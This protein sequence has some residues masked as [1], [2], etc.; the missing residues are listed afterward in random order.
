M[1][2]VLAI[3]ARAAPLL[4]LV[5]VGIVGLSGLWLVVSNAARRGTLVERGGIDIGPPQ[6]AVARLDARLM[7][8]RRGTDMAARLQSA[9]VERSVGHFY[10]MRVVIVVVAFF[11]AKLLFPLILALL[12]AVAAWWAGHFWLQRKL[13]R[14][15]EEFVVQLPELARLLSNG[16]S[17]GL[18]VPAALELAVREIDNPAKAELQT[19][20]DEMSLGRSLDESLEALA[21]RLPSREVAVLMSCIVIQ[22]RAGGD[23]VHALRGLSETLENRRE[24]GREVR[25]IMAG[26]VYTAYVVPFLGLGSLLMLNAI[27]SDT[28]SRMTST[29][30]GIV[31]LIVAFVLYFI[32]FVAIRRATRV[33]L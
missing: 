29:A 13:D 3:S 2:A 21:R 5:G 10:L 16:A 22:Q 6:T 4:T 11:I 12:V 27:N 20:L 8:S 24:T 33:E 26:A 28:L 31:V 1:I 15:G 32:A 19:V 18:S 7:R 25:T 23:T 30:V 9:G 17:A 14:R